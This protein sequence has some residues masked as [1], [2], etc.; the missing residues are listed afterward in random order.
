M[1]AAIGANLMAAFFCLIDAWLQEPRN[2]PPLNREKSG[3]RRRM[4]RLRE[5][6]LTE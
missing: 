2:F 6:K 3:H 5:M 1:I 4:P